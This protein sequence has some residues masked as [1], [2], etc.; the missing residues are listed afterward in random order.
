M[1]NSELLTKLFPDPIVRSV[2]SRVNVSYGDAAPRYHTDYTL[3]SSKGIVLKDMTEQSC[4]GGLGWAY[5][6]AKKRRKKVYLHYTPIYT[7][8]VSK[9]TSYR[10]IKLGQALGIFPTDRTTKNIINEGLRINL[11]DKSL[12]VAELYLKLG[13]FRWIREA[14]RLVNGVVDLVYNAGCDVWASAVFCHYYDITRLDHSLLPFASEN[15][16]S[17][18]YLRGSVDLGLV[19]KMHQLTRNPLSVDNR[20]FSDVCCTEVSTEGGQ[21]WQWQNWAVKPLKSFYLRDRAMLLSSEVYP[22]I[23]SRNPGKVSSLV[24]RLK[25][26]SE[27]VK[28]EI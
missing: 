9:D 25:E 24:V 19:L 1:A 23:A 11:D 21:F 8:I 13:F 4:F 28:F 22:I 12:G 17:S 10:W 3:K 6:E 27:N 2:V 7:D 18:S 20:I 15:I 5:S 14:P 16:Y 26:N